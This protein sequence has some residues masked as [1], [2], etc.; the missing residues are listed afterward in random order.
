LDDVVCFPVIE[1]PTL[2]E[3]SSGYAGSSTALGFEGKLELLGDQPLNPRGQGFH[4]PLLSAA[5]SYAA[6]HG[7]LLDRQ[8]LKA[9]LRDSI[10]T[11]PKSPQRQP[12]DVERYLSDAYLDDIIASTVEN[13]AGP[14]AIP[15]HFVS[16]PLPI[17]EAMAR[18]EKTIAEWC[19]AAFASN[20]FGAP[21]QLVGSH[22]LLER[23]SRQLRIHATSVSQLIIAD[24]L[25]V[26][27]ST[28]VRGW[29]SLPVS[30]MQNR[31]GGSAE[32]SR[33]RR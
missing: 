18:L 4:N 24:L 15:S 33:V 21:P 7:E 10:R 1:A 6:K 19:R 25:R 28:V 30:L 16:A 13:Y 12:A 22:G 20:N 8:A 2:R 9:R 3:K 14:A 17:A 11:A 31:N 27:S 23:L 32:P 29:A 5:A 26:S